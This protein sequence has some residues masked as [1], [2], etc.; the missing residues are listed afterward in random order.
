MKKLSILLLSIFAVILI[1]C[2]GS[3]RY[4][5]AWK[6]TNPDGLKYD[7]IFDTKSLTIN[8]TTG[9]SQKF[10]YTQNSVEFN[11]SVEN[12]GI[13]LGN[14]TKLKLTFPDSKQESLGLIKDEAGNVMYTIS[15]SAYIR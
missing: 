14:G 15:R 13:N 2:S 3:D 4:R 1:G 7:I 9:K 10:D 12:Y 6:A 8:D 5:G 11:N